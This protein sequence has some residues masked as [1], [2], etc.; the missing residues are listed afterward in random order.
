MPPSESPPR[1]DRR[2]TPVRACGRERLHRTV[3]DRMSTVPGPRRRLGRAVAVPVL[4]VGR[5]LG[6]LA[7]PARP[8]PLR[9]NRPSRR[10]PAVPRLTRAVVSCPSTCGL[11]LTGTGF[12]CRTPATAAWIARARPRPPHGPPRRR[13]RRSC[14]VRVPCRSRRNAGSR[15]DGTPGRWCMSRR[16]SSRGSCAGTQINL[17]SPPASSRMRNMPIVRHSTNTPGNRGSPT[18]T[19][20]ASSGSPSSPRV[21]STNP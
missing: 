8:S 2:S 11:N 9:G 4:R 6:R 21:S 16:C 14:P 20:S 10:R 13:P 17:S 19:S 1:K 7:E 5:M 12:M 18:V 3:V 15:A